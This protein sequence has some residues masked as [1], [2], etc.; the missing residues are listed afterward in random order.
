MANGRKMR[1]ASH[2]LTQRPHS[3]SSWLSTRKAGPI[4]RSVKI[5]PSYFPRSGQ[6]LY[7]WQLI[8]QTM[9]NIITAK[10]IRLGSSS[11]GVSSGALLPGRASNTGTMGAS[12]DDVSTFPTLGRVVLTLDSTVDA[13]SPKMVRASWRF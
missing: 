4:L 11:K 8:Q 9:Q 7:N 5:R 6:Y 13:L 2:S 10:F 1:E 12:A 3:T